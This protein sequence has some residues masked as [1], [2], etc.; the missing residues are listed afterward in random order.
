MVVTVA[1]LLLLGLVVGFLG[2][3]IGAGGG[4]L[5]APLLAI[6]YPRAEPEHVAAISLAVVFFNALSGSIG[7]ARL[8]RIDYRAGK[9]FALAAVPGSIAGAIL[10][11][12]VPRHL[13]DGVLAAALIGMGLWL[14]THGAEPRASGTGEGHEGPHDRLGLGAAISAG[15][16]IL[17]SILGIGGGIIHVPALVKILGFPVHVA[18][19]TSH[20]VLA[21]TSGVGVAV[22]ASRGLLDDHLVEAACMA[23]GAVAG[24][25]IGAHASTRLAG[26]HIVRG[27]AVAIIVVGARMAYQAGT[28][29]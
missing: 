28:S 15:V 27:L 16:G 9:V 17:S 7:Y 11:H 20:F 12:W 6:A 21:I 10:V 25:Q 4:F 5:L 13:F 22:L 24:A 8:G 23:I 18:T 29:G 19:A 3:L 14:L 26:H 2:T 1:L